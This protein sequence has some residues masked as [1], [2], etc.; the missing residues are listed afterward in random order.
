MEKHLVV[1]KLYE[2]DIGKNS[3]YELHEMGIA[4]LF[5]EIFKKKMCY[6][7]ESK[8]WYVYDGKRWVKDT[9]NLTVMEFCKVFTY[10]LSE[11]G[12]GICSDKIIKFA[13]SLCNV[14]RRSL[15]VK[16]VMSV[17]PRSLS[18][19]DENLDLIN[20]QNGTYDLSNKEF[21]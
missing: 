17:R 3:K 14:K 10:G 5:F 12:I 21:L 4:E 11:Y 15:I 18:E 6:V 2:L 19:F 16:D 20:L 8:C 9:Q 7:L 13:S 1:E